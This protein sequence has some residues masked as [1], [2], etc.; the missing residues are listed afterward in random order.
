VR[1]EGYQ[2]EDVEPENAPNYYSAC[3]KAESQT[4]SESTP[5]TQVKSP[6]RLATRHS[7]QRSFSV[8]EN[9]LTPLDELGGFFFSFLKKIPTP[10]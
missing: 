6:I 10:I 3:A 9:Q 4:A 7:P 2:R 1:R 5:K 8:S